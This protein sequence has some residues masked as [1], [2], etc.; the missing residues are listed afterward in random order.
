MERNDQ[1]SR[2]GFLQGSATAASIS[3]EPAQ[4]VARTAASEGEA[5]LSVDDQGIVRVAT[6]TLEARIDKGFLTSLKSKSSG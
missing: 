5:R 6:K 2:R 1:L 4:D 3:L